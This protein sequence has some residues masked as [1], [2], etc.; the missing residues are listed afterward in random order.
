MI[1]TAFCMKDIDQFVAS[2]SKDELRTFLR[3]LL[4]A[5]EQRDMDDILETVREWSEDK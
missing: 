2:L 3:C 1:E 5:I 4:V